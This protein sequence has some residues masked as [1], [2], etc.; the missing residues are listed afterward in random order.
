MIP[1]L[2]L[3]ALVK[4]I[5]YSVTFFFQDLRLLLQSPYKFAGLTID[6]K[7]HVLLNIRGKVIDNPLCKTN[8]KSLYAAQ[9][10]W[11]SLYKGY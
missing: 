3:E 1:S 7:R 8:V 10:N 4:R 2:E 5:Y 11:D 9:E 6:V